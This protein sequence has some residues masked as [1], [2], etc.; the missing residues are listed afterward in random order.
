MGESMGQ[1]DFPKQE[2][3]KQVFL[4]KEKKKSESNKKTTDLMLELDELKTDKNRIDAENQE[5]DEQIAQKQNT[6][7]FDDVP[8]ENSSKPVK[9]GG[10]YSALSTKQDVLTAQN[11]IVLNG[12]TISADTSVLATKTDLAGKQ[13]TITFD[14]SPTRYS[15]NAVKSG[16]VFD[17]LA[18]KQDIILFDTVPRANSTS[19]ITSGGVY[20][21]LQN[22]GGN[23]TIDATPTQ[24][25]QNAVS[26]GG[27]FSAL[28]SKQDT[29]TAGTGIDITNGVISAT[30]GS[31]GL[32]SVSASDVDSE[33]ATSGQ[34]LTA[35]GNGG[36]SWQTISGGGMTQ[37]QETKLNQTYNYFLTHVVE[38]DPSYNPQSYSDYPAGTIFQT[39]AKF[40]Q[41]SNLT[42]TTTLTTPNMVF[43][44]IDNSSG[45]LNIKLV[46]T[47]SSTFSGTIDVYQNGTS[48]Y[49]ELYNFNDSSLSYIFESV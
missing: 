20:T 44:A 34:V 33:S 35:D 32:S 14:N 8:T 42:F 37:E 1:I 40:S 16:G 10:V 47:C 48:I 15:S 28:S 30:G 26:S 36:A 24:N 29:L 18:L 13:N 11:G 21:A 19:P 12:S 43:S 38:P 6:L 39:Y 31:G 22:V 27:V 25:S 17:A 5:Q 9:S 49:H 45:N 23:I 46:F 7:Q 2:K 3:P 4:G 41:R